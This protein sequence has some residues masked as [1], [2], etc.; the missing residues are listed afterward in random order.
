LGGP[1]RER[2]RGADHQARDTGRERRYPT[3]IALGPSALLYVLDSGDRESSPVR[4]SVYSLAG[5]LLR[6][7][8]VATESDPVPNM[9]VDSVGN[10][11]VVAAR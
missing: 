1:D 4:M 6:R 9:V 5:R 3:R 8:R 10:A 7:W 2:A 11:Y